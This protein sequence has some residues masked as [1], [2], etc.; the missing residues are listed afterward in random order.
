MK[1]R[2]VK[3]SIPDKRPIIN[4]FLIEVSLLLVL[5]FKINKIKV[6]KRKRYKLADEIWDAE[7]TMR[8][9]KLKNTAPKKDILESKNF[10]IIL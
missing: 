5:K 2:L 1:S 10:E 8:G 4:K 3:I 7:K 6:N 9:N